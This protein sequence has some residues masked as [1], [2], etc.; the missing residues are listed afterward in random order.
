VEDIAAHSRC[1]RA[2]G[3]FLTL[4]LLLYYC[5]SE[6]RYSALEDIR[7]MKVKDLKSWPQCK[8]HKATW[9]L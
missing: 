6:E 3:L 5:I 2:A 4:V 1:C 7:C 9:T 8:V